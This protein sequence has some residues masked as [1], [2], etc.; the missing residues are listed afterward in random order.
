M[1]FNRQKTV[2]VC[3]LLVLSFVV[4][5]AN[6]DTL[7][8]KPDSVIGGSS[9]TATL[10]LD[11][12]PAQDTQFSVSISNAAAASTNNTLRIASGQR[13]IEFPIT[14][15]PVQSKQRVEILVSESGKPIAKADLGILAPELTSLSLSQIA[16]VGGTPNGTLHGTVSISGKA[17]AG[18]LTISLGQS[19]ANC[20]SCAGCNQLVQVPVSIQIS[21]GSQSAAFD[22]QTHATTSQKNFTI[23]ASLGGQT[24]TASFELQTLRP[25][26]ITLSP[27]SVSGTNPTTV[28]V[29]LNAPAY[30]GYQLGVTCTQAL[31][32]ELHGSTCG[33][34]G[35][36]NVDFQAGQ[37]TGTFHLNSVQPL[38]QPTQ[39]TIQAEAVSINGSVQAVLTISP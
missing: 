33:S 17:P 34:H 7:L 38:Q 13:K 32:T 14:T 19:C 25:Q 15:N 27:T 22:I 37:Q 4:M 10:T 20:G 23:L 21:G 2:F 36:I 31:H 11:R 18:G 8:L 35:P 28:T 24:K 5:S 9:V 12:P 26:S 3:L 30:Q 1:Q 39:V 16:V 29:T 6:A